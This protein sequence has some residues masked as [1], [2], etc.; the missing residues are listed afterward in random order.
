M[1]GN[2][3]NQNIANKGL[4]TRKVVLFGSEQ[5]GKTALMNRYVHDSYDDNTQSTIG[6][7]F[8]SKRVAFDD[9]ELRIQYFDTAGKKNFR[10]IVKSYYQKA[11]FS[12]GVFDLTNPASLND[13]NYQIRDIKKINPNTE[14]CIIGTKL[15]LKDRRKITDDMIEEFKQQHNIKKHNLVS[16][17]A[18]IIGHNIGSIFTYIADQ[19]SK[20]YSIDDTYL[21]TEYLIYFINL[22]ILQMEGSRSLTYNEGQLINSAKLVIYQSYVLLADIH[23][24]K[25]DKNLERN[26]QTTLRNVYDVLSAPESKEKVDALQK[27][28]NI[29]APGHSVLWK[30]FAGA[31]IMFLGVAII[32]LSIAGLPF[33]AGLSGSGI[34]GGALVIAAGGY[35]FRSGMQQGIAKQV[36]HMANTVKINF[37]QR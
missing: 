35:V 26:L 22:K 29:S 14:I 4:K 23:N 27:N 3:Q 25:N 12:I 11:D 30:K 10:S 19:L 5:S 6:A 2:R 17:K 32:G 24:S 13:L 21:P 7:S 8:Y 37:F 9:T 36:D 16:A 1:G 28:V 31:V 15:D 20:T 34:A 18:P 33:T